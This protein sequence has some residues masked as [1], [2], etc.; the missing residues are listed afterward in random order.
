MPKVSFTF[1]GYVK[2]ATID[3]A[4]DIASMKDIDV[5][6]M[7]AKELLKK[8]RDGELAISFADAYADGDGSVEM[9]DFIEEGDEDP[10]NNS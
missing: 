3:Q 1:T 4:F 2:D 7:P 8:I 5:S 10:E 9:G 6:K